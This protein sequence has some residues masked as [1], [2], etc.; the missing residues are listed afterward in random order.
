MALTGY[1]CLLQKRSEDI[2]RMTFAWHTDLIHSWSPG[3]SVIVTAITWPQ[4]RQKGPDHLTHTLIGCLHKEVYS[5]QTDTLRSALWDCLIYKVYKWC[6]RICQKSGQ[7]VVCL[8]FGI[9]FTL[10]AHMQWLKMLP[11]WE[12]SGTESIAN[13]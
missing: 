10:Q 12:D 7:K 5:Q 13:K 3:V 6:H 4:D 9:V 8:L 2:L 11:V 1:R